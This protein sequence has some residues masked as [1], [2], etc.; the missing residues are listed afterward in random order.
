MRRSNLLIEQEILQSLIFNGPQKLTNMAC[1]VRT[2]CNKLKKM[3]EKLNKEG[4]V[5]QKNI[6]NY[7]L[8]LITP[9]GLDFYRKSG[10]QILTI[11]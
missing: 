6:F 5:T 8:Y 4:L 7:D 2:S 1:V 3:L 11:Q 10:N 9:K